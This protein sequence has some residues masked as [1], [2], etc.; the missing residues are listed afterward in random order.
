MNQ[1]RIPQTFQTMKTTLKTNFNSKKNLKSTKKM[2]VS[3]N[4][5]IHPKWITII[6]SLTT[7]TLAPVKTMCTL[8]TEVIL[9]PMEVASLIPL[10]QH[11]TIITA[12]SWT[13]RRAIWLG[14]PPSSVIVIFHSKVNVLRLVR[15]SHSSHAHVL[16]G[17]PDRPQKPLLI[18]RTSTSLKL[19][20]QAKHNFH[21]CLMLILFYF[22]PD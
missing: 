19:G 20:Q 9:T 21:W 22:L 1:I 17:T 2:A 14:T 5:I 10:S 15:L 8:T 3:L 16:V 6:A 12:H 7:P 13:R 11:V 18:D 4:E